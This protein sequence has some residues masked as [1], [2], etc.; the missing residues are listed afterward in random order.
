METLSGFVARLTKDIP[1]YHHPRKDPQKVSLTKYNTPN[2]QKMAL[3]AVVTE[4]DS[5]FKIKTKAWLANEQCKKIG[6]LTWFGHGTEPDGTKLR[7]LDFYVNK[8]SK[9]QDFQIAVCCLKV[10]R[11]KPSL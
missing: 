9:G 2:P 10:I 1:C 7:G 8:G 5:K 6:K 11:N 3:F 4:L